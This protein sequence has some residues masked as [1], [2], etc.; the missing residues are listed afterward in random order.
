M[1]ESHKIYLMM[2]KVNTNLVPQY[3]QPVAPVTSLNTYNT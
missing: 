1:I 3:L 2:Y